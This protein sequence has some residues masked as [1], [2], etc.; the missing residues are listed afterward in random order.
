MPGEKQ[1]R[2]RKSNQKETIG[3]KNNWKKK[4]S[5]LEGI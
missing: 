1:R 4:L 3:K 5:G 2:V